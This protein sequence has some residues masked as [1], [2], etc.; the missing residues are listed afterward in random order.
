[1]R[2]CEDTTMPSEPLSPSLNPIVN[3]LGDLIHEGKVLKAVSHSGWRYY[4][5]TFQNEIDNLKKTIINGGNEVSSGL[6]QYS[7]LF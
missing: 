6:L 4:G 1:M 2:G 5:E 7:I 3:K